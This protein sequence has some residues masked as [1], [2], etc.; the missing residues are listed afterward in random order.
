ML[1]NVS[2]NT[3]GEDTNAGLFGAVCFYHRC[4]FCLGGLPVCDQYQQAR[5]G[6][7]I[8]GSASEEHLISGGTQ[9]QRNV[10]VSAGDVQSPYRLHNVVDVVIRTQ[11]E[12]QVHS[13]TELQQPDLHQANAPHHHHHHHFSERELTFT[14]AICCRS[15]V[16]RLS[17]NV[18]APYSTGENFRQCFYAIWY[19]SHL[20]TSTEY[21][22][23]IVTG[24]PFRR[25]GVKR[26]REG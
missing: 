15:S 18:R 7:V 17:V 6:S 25:E 10:S 24:K 20:L 26:T 5:Y 1:I 8:G 3:D 14:F 9:G 4:P 12:A 23:E 11:M 21:F 2:A 16:C 19:L 13:V 22:M